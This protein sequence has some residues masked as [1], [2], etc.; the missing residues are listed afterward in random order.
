MGTLFAGTHE[1]RTLNH[2]FQ[3]PNIDPIA[4]RL[5][6]VGIHWY[7]IS[8]LVG[9]ICVYLWMNRSTGRRRL[10]LSSDQIQDFLMYALAGVLVGGR[11]LFVIADML[12]KHN[13]AEYLRNPINF[14]AVWNGGM[15]FHGGLI[16][17]MIAL[18]LFVHKHRGLTYA[19]LID[20]V[21]VLLPVGIAL[22]RVVNFI[23]DELWGRICVPDHPWCIV[24]GAGA[25]LGPDYRYPSQLFECALDILTL[26]VLLFL[27]RMKLPDGVVGWAWFTMYGITRS[28]AE[29]WRQPDITAGPITG[30]QMLALP[31]I[32]IG[33][34]MITLCYRRGVRTDERTIGTAAS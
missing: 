15:A 4:F 28:I 31:M 8:Y 23:N 11:T 22:T 19:V 21:V 20:E 7:G 25:G 16:G 14:V 5:G 12:S 6:P 34:V 32:A 1:A 9:F 18:A 2:W 30:G 27:Y 3:Y 10:G 13:A 29:I 24:P 33:A 17:V 26:P